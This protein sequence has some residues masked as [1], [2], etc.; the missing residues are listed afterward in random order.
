VSVST[1]DFLS[2]GGVLAELIRSKDWSQ[3][4]LGPIDQWPQ[5]LRTTVSLCLAS[6]FPINIVWGEEHTQIYNDGYRIV[7]GDAHPKALGESYRVTWASAWPA[8]GAPFENALLGETSFLENQRMFLTRNGYLEETF[9]TFSTSPI[10]DES[11]G[12]G[13]LFHPVTETTTTMLAERRTRALRDLTAHFSLTASVPELVSALI[14]T[15]AGFEYDLP[16]MLVYEHDGGDQYK[17]LDQFGLVEPSQDRFQT[18]PCDAS[19]PWPFGDAITTRR[20]AEFGIGPS[21]LMDGSAGPYDEAPNRGF[22]IPIDVAGSHM[23]P[24]I[25]V[26]GASPRLP[27]D[28]AYRGFYELLS[29]SITA[30]LAGVRAREDERRRVEALAEIDR[31]KTTFFSNVSHEFRTPLTLMLGPIEDALDDGEDL[32]PR[33]R[34]RLEVA[35]RNARRLLKLVNALLDFSRIEAGRVLA[36][37]EAVDLSEFTAELASN[38]RSACERAGIALIVDCPPLSRPVRVDRDMWEKIVLNLLSNAFKFTFSGSITVRL[39]QAGLDVRLVVED[40]GVGIRSDELP[41][42][43]DR[44]HRVEGQRGRSH[45]GTGIGLS[46]VK[47]LL[48]LQGGTIAAV[49]KQ[50]LGTA[51]TATLPLGV[52]TDRVA[53]EAG[54]SESDAASVY[55]EEALRWLP[56]AVPNS[57]E[58]S[59]VTDASKALGERPRILLAD[60]NADMRA[61][62]RRILEEGGYQVEAVENGAA[63]LAAVKNFPA[64]DLVLSDVMMPELDG[65]GLLA[66]IR[67]DPALE[68]LLVILLSAR[69]GAEARVEGLSAGADDYLVKPFGTRELLARVDGAIKLARQREHATAREQELEAT[70][71]IERGRVE[72]QATE[73]EL[74]FALKAGRLG[75]WEVDLA[76][77]TLIASEICR[78]VFGLPPDVPYQ[79]EDLVDRIDPRDMARRQAEIERSIRERSD[80]EIEYRIQRPDGVIAWILIRGKAAYDAAGNPTRLAG[81][82]LDVTDRKRTEER[83]RLLLDELN[84]RVKNTLAT[85]QSISM[86][87]RRTADSPEAFGVALDGR[88]AALSGAHDLLTRTTWDGA[89]LS[90]VIALTLRPYEAGGSDRRVTVRGPA[91][92]LDPNAAVTLSMAFHELATNAAKYGALS[93][94]GGSVAIV[95]NKIDA[96]PAVI[97]IAWKEAGGPTVALPERRGFGS[98][99]LEQG[100]AREM[101]GAV[102][103]HYDSDG[104]SCI[105]RFPVSSKLELIS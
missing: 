4:P 76:N 10:R 96:E 28:D 18:L 5:S 26:A 82:S 83:Q 92:R 87:T 51:F 46:L 60:D 43:F 20:A 2:S 105:M 47:E 24:M 86:Q 102:T 73:Q 80:L 27:L 48:A 62:V 16:L 84:H 101:K 9:F 49:S 70:I 6:N 22:V 40:T 71:E 57:H 15:L 44:F 104:I 37:L 36:R 100:L 41:R 52:E 98:R 31:A 94:E 72:L 58:P 90:D 69:A 14:T 89:M 11:G 8:I 19:G 78:D 34:E 64:P 91:V 12:I 97:E 85:V 77:N 68:G 63:A 7:C 21:V 93:T 23:P 1:A 66:A 13:G 30:A 35:H 53:G 74:A 79:Y 67:A 65:Y 29:A 103:L 75:S 39:I 17:L 55:V 3:T 61:F 25:V 59:P 33:Q 56:D 81:V 32:P 38:F 99:L 45:E 54:V 95:W 88:L 42:I 50:G